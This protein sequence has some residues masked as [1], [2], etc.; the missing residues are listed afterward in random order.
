MIVSTHLAP[1]NPDDRPEIVSPLTPK[2][3]CERMNV[4]S[5]PSSLS[6]QT[7]PGTDT[8]DILTRP[9]SCPYEESRPIS[10][11][12]EGQSRP[13]TCPKAEEECSTRCP[14]EPTHP[15]SCPNAEPTCPIQ[16]SDCQQNGP[17]TCI[18]SEPIYPTHGPDTGPMIPNKAAEDC[19]KPS[20]AVPEPE[21]PRSKAPIPI[22]SSPDVWGDKERRSLLPKEPVSLGAGLEEKERSN[23]SMGKE[24]AGSN[25][26][27]ERAKNAGPGTSKRGLKMCLLMLLALIFLLALALGIGLGVGLG[28]KK[29]HRNPS[30]SQNQSTPTSSTSIA[31]STNDIV[32]ISPSSGPIEGSDPGST[33]SSNAALNF[34]PSKALNCTGSEN[35]SPKQPINGTG[36]AFT[37][38]PDYRTP[39]SNRIFAN[40]YYQEPSKGDLYIHQLYLNGTWSNLKLPIDYQPKLNT[41]IAALP[42]LFKNDTTWNIFFVTTS[43][44]IYHRLYHDPG[45]SG[46]WGIY[47][48]ASSPMPLKDKTPILACS[49]HYGSRNTTNGYYAEDGINLFFTANTTSENPSGS[50]V[51]MWTY[52]H[53]TWTHTYTWH[54]ASLPIGC[55]SRERSTVAGVYLTDNS[56]RVTSWTRDMNSDT[57]SWS[58]CGASRAVP[59][60]RDTFL[61][62]DGTWVYTLLQG[63]VRAWEYTNVWDCEATQA[64]VRGPW[65]VASGVNRT[66]VGAARLLLESE[67]EM[68]VAFYQEGEGTGLLG[69]VFNKTT[70]VWDQGGEVLRC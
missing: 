52:Q 51:E 38:H 17:T 3:S 7:C 33:S 66:S 61:K 18:E 37:S 43:N 8:D 24:Y 42:T 68:P 23:S 49:F 25:S 31:A 30:S 1:S 22:W 4:I 5:R 54:G 67:R 21:C 53:Y 58:A 40:L 2:E 35:P 70:G 63:E 26:D 6:G 55:D 28:A 34:Q 60:E 32:P 11:P 15:I 50:A 57:S 12:N 48:D 64:E 13:P 41:P 29:H 46:G 59:W 56:G 62:G 36:I 9:I 65:V 69:S 44:R 20:G 19:P 10:C 14:E 27:L 45:F 39:G 47:P 16:R